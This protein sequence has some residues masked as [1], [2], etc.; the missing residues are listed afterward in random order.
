MA[1]SQMIRVFDWQILQAHIRRPS[2][3]L[4]VPMLG[5]RELPIANF[6]AELAYRAGDLCLQVGI[7]FH[8]AG[9]VVAA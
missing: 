8:E 9:D 5:P 3:A 2:D 6:V 1:F 4:A 7:G